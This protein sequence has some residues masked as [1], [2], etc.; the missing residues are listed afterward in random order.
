MVELTS[1]P[2]GI[3]KGNRIILKD[4]KSPNLKAVWNLMK[5]IGLYTDKTYDE[6]MDLY[7]DRDS[8]FMKYYDA[9]CARLDHMRAAYEICV[10]QVNQN[11]PKTVDAV[12]E[13]AKEKEKQRKVDSEQEREKLMKEREER[14]KKQK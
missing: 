9:M 2:G 13:K 10:T 11:V 7:L 8:E 3:G 14:R 4:E 1:Q 12:L 5:E 6:V